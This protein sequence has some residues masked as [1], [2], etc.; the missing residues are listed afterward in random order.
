MLEEKIK[1]S[2]TE[3]TIL[4]AAEEIFLEKGFSGAKTIEIAKKAGVN[5]A[6]LHYY[7]RTK[8]NLF[9]KV[10]E[11]KARLLV[12]SFNHIFEQDLPIEEKIRASVGHH[13]DFLAA[14]PKLPMF[15]LSEVL[16]SSDRKDRLKALLRPVATHLFQSVQAS[17]DAE[18]EKGRIKAVYA[19]DTI[20]NAVSLNVFTIIFSQIVLTE[21]DAVF[22]DAQDFIQDR[23]EKIIGFIL[24]S[25]GL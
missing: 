9:N 1:D 14:N 7:Y 6:M 3:Q 15:I 4:Q 19:V 16:T 2:N 10:F 20:L 5:H 24:N 12:N 22:G 23:R 11:A 13:F 8:E 17:I 25:I 21:N 18:V